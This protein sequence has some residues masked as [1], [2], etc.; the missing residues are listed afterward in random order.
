MI[1]VV[2]VV[3][4]C[5]VRGA[6]QGLAMVVYEPDLPAGDDQC[7]TGS[8]VV[9]LDWDKIVDIPVLVVKSNRLVDQPGDLDTV[10]DSGSGTDV[11]EVVAGR[12]YSTC[13]KS[14]D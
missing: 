13:L 7:T 3:D 6:R 8:I 5:T 14:V 10:L 4:E 12:G 2:V 1:V 9:D 11:E